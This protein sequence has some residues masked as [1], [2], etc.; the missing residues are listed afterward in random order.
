[1]E[2]EI[3]A[4]DQENEKTEPNNI[5][6]NNIS[7]PKNNSS[8]QVIEKVDG[9]SMHDEADLVIDILNDELIS[10][11][12]QKIF[13]EFY[14]M[15]LCVIISYV[16]NL[17]IS[18]FIDSAKELFEPCFIAVKSYLAGEPFREFELSMY[19]HR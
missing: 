15:S 18:I 11:V 14:Q 13:S 12:K 17:I 19:F 2:E 7:S 16:C 9:Q 8:Q 4:I 5:S 10:Q 3:K 1:M 6:Q